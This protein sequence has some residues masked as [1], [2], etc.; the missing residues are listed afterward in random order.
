MVPSPLALHAGAGHWL[1]RAHSSQGPRAYIQSRHQ[2]VSVRTSFSS[3][4][5]TDYARV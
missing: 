3:D 5:F 4:T 1:S 2:N